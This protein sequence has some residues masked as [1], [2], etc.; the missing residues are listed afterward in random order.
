MFEVARYHANLKVQARDAKKLYVID[1]GLRNVSSR[2]IQDDTG[3]LLKN[4]VFLQLKRAEAEVSYYRGKREVDF[5]V[6]EQY[7]PVSAI[8]VCASGIHSEETY[9][10]EVLALQEALTD[11]GLRHGQIITLNREETLRE[12]GLIIALTPAHKWLLTPE[13]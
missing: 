11:L 4:L 12:N 8:Q 3:K 9:K 5:I 1:T 6:T 2:S 13:I 7:K 10:R